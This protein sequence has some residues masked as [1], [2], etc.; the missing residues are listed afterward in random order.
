MDASTTLSVNLAC[1]T[2]VHGLTA[3]FI[4]L[5]ISGLRSPASGLEGGM[6]ELSEDMV[7]LHHS[8]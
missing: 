7:L 3:S 1:V 8:V 6:F 4:E 5:Q 2:G